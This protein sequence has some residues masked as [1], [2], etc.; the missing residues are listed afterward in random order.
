MQVG[1]FPVLAAKDC[2]VD[3]KNLPLIVM[4]HGR[5]GSFLANRDT[6]QVLADAGFVVVAVSHPGDNAQDAS[7][8]NDLSAFVDRPAEIKRLVDYLLD[9]WGQR[10]VIDATRIGSSASLGAVTP[11]WSLWVPNLDST[12]PSG[13]ARV[14]QA[15]SATRFA[16]VACYLRSMTA[17]SKRRSSRIR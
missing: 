17:A 3:G 13:C 1:P 10:G 7:H 12:R 4:S 8:S 6:A 14:K 9:S 11:G 16:A 15:R 5:T 2:P